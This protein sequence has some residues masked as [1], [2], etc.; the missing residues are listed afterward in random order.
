M[1]AFSTERRRE[2][3]TPDDALTAHLCRP[4]E[5]AAAILS[6]PLLASR[7]SEATMP[8]RKRTR[9]EQEQGL[10]LLHVAA[11]NTLHAFACG[12]AAA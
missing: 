1:A 2:L 6:P 12:K 3:V 8:S 4:S 10:V 11:L 7:Y 5:T 9:E